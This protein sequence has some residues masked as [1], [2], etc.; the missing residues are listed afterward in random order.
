MIEYIRGEVVELT[1]ASVVLETNGIG[2][3]LNISLLKK[4]KKKT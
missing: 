4:K 3:F 2:Y 1:P